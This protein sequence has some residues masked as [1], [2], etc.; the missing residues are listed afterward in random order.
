MTR[1]EV[2]KRY[3]RIVAHLIAES[4]GYMTPLHA[5]GAVKAFIDNE[6]WYCEWYS[7]MAGHRK[8]LAGLPD[9]ESRYKVVTRETAINAIRNR[10]SHSGFMASYQHAKQLVQAELEHAGCTRDLF[11]SWF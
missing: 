8:D 5:A 4:L 10:R 9:W 1:E 2:L 7:H 3:P 6:A 11:A